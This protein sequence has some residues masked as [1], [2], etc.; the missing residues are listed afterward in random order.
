MEFHALEEHG[1]EEQ[2]LE[3]TDQ[4]FHNVVDMDSYCHSFCDRLILL[5]S[6]PRSITNPPFNMKTMA[7]N[8]STCMSTSEMR[9]LA[10]TGKRKEQ[11]LL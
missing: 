4:H 2:G 6:C 10:Q 5:K 3:G 7:N 1:D 11:Y 8:S 9:I